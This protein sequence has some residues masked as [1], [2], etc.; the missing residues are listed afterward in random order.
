M[1]CWRVTPHVLQKQ[2]HPM[3]ERSQPQSCRAEAGFQSI[4]VEVFTWLGRI[5]EEQVTFCLFGSYN[6]NSLN[7][8][9]TKNLFMYFISLII[10]GSFWE[11]TPVHVLEVNH[12][13][14][15]ATTPVLL[16]EKP[17]VPGFYLASAARADPPTLHAAPSCFL[18]AFSFNFTVF[19]WGLDPKSQTLGAVNSCWEWR[20]CSCLN[21]FSFG[22]SPLP[23]TPSASV[24]L[25]GWG[26]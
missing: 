7:T 16:I 2:V 24:R 9:W 13:S 6:H 11:E 4:V 17:L 26:L 18:P 1:T 22:E 14:T 19:R 20:K 3:R 15:S 25:A 8:V 21:K 23:M 10:H 12:V 5:I